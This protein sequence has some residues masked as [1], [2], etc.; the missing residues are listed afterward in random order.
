VPASIGW[1][2]LVFLILQ[3]FEVRPE[4]TD[5]PWDPNALPQVDPEQDL[6]RGELIVGLV[7][8]I[9]ILVLVV[10]FPQW[11]GFV[12]YPGGTFY[13]NPVILRY[14][15]WIILSL[16]AGVGLNI[17]LLRQGRWELG[18]RIAKI[19]VNLLNLGVLFL[20]YRGHSVWL[21]DRG[22]GGFLIALKKFPE[23]LDQGWELIGMHAFRLAFGV[24]LVI[25]IIETA[26]LMI[27]LLR[28]AFL[29]E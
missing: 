28:S 12:T 29:Q 7:F 26:V 25:T 2:V 15:G 8:S 17:Y 14:L 16:L 4:L 10:F 18:T 22:A 27:R 24:A 21:A 19:A 5:Q 11:I 1:V 13:S 23:L 6:K 3:R 20:L 9:L